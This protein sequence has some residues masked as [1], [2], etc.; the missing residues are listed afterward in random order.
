[1]SE[2]R[3]FLLASLRDL[4]AEHD[5]GDL[6]DAD[7]TAL[8]DQYIAR[9]ARTA[10]LLGAE[11]DARASAPA[12]KRRR[13]LAV[14]VVIVVAGLAGWA[15]ASTAGE[16]TASDQA[17][18]GLPEGSTDRITRAQALVSQGQILEAVKVYDD[19]L[20]DDPENPVALAQRGWLISKVDPS[21]VDSG[22]ANVEKAIA[23]DPGY[24]EA[25]FFRAMILLQAKHQP[26]AAAEEFDRVLAANP[27]PGIA[28]VAQQYRQ[29]ALEQAAAG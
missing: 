29:Q 4:D 8:R 1:M 5:A 23:V 9:T 17:T 19:L 22:L 6:D 25:R 20:R 15:V 28:Q 13:A 3:E 16:R 21:L 2:E 18:G 14:L 7:Y 27:P 24:A 26:A 10:A 12:P 11:A